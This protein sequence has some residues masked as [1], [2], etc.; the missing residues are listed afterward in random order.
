MKNT[1]EKIIN[2][3]VCVWNEDYSA[4]L[5]SI[6]K[7]AGISRMTLHRHFCGRDAI[8][9]AIVE[10]F[11]EKIV[12]ILNQAEK[13]QD[14]PIQ[15]MEYLVKNTHRLVEDY[16]F[17]F[18]LFEQKGRPEDLVERF[19]R[20]EDLFETF[21][22]SIQ[23]K[24]VVKPTNAL[25]EGVMKSGFRMKQK[26]FDQDLDLAEMIWDAYQSAIFTPESIEQYKAHS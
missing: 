18:D 26:G 23:A 3:A 17:L 9:L 1:Y 15:Q 14:V 4:P 13:G 22:I 5:K 8:L 24:G 12:L 19:K 6:A 7:E 25:F 10:D 2:A 16:N 21:F 11:I 20:F